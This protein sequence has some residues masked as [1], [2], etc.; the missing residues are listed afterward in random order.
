MVKSERWKAYLHGKKD[1]TA[2][3]NDL[4]VAR[5]ALMEVGSVIKVPEKTPKQLAEAIKISREEI[6]TEMK[7][8]IQQ[9]QTLYDTVRP[10][11]TLIEAQQLEKDIGEIK[12][13]W[14]KTKE[15]TKEIGDTDVAAKEAA[16]T[17]QKV[18]DEEMATVFRPL[19]AK[20]KNL[21]I[22]CRKLKDQADVNRTDILAA[23]QSLTPSS[24]TGSAP[25][26]QNGRLKLERIPI[27][28]FSGKMQDYPT[29]KDDWEVLVNDRAEQ[30]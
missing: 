14:K 7:Y 10:S 18:L 1:Y 15:L 22:S 29:F 6:V 20:V 3:K 9:A 26:G 21:G 25:W 30:G 24:P 11:E 4:S 13:L 16:Q 28:T 23:T 27:P 2:L 12:Q 19:A 17:D 5:L 8:E